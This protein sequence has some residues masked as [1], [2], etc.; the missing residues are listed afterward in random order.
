[1]EKTIKECLKEKTIELLKEIEERAEKDNLFG[2]H[3]DISYNLD[4]KNKYLFISLERENLEDITIDNIDNYE[5]VTIVD[6]RED[7]DCNI[8]DLIID[9]LYIIKINEERR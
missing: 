8:L 9:W 1:M 3:L 7:Y 5:D 2:Y 4:L 6:F